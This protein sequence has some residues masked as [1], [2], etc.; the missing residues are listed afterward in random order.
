MATKSTRRS[1]KN[2]IISPPMEVGSVSP[3]VEGSFIGLRMHTLSATGVSQSG[4][5]R[6]SVHEGVLM[7]RCRV[8]IANQLY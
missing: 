8:S 1:R 3:P 6:K 2:V 4:A 7:K 5:S